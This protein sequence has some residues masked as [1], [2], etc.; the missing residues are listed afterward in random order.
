MA[1]VVM[2]WN[3]GAYEPINEE[4]S[5]E[6][7]SVQQEDKVQFVFLHED[8]SKEECELVY[9]GVTDVEDKEI[10]QF[11]NDFLKFELHI[12][13]GTGEEFGWIERL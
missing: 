9:M 7:E 3:Q 12:S 13:N 5:R 6:E 4:C 11:K 10:I 2:K 8:G 1:K